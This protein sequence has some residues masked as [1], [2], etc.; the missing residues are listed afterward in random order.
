MPNWNRVQILNIIASSVHNVELI[1]I[2]GR[3]PCENHKGKAIQTVCIV[4]WHD[5][6]NRFH[7]EGVPIRGSLEINKTCKCTAVSPSPLRWN[8]YKVVETPVIG[9]SF[10]TKTACLECLEVTPFPCWCQNRMTVSVPKSDWHIFSW[11]DPAGSFPCL[12]RVITILARPNWWHHTGGWVYPVGL[13]RCV[14]SKANWRLSV[15]QEFC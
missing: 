2:Q 13:Q 8:S 11:H 6:W 4:W 15:K 9:S 14:G 5:L 10:K 3:S 1:L 7:L 12:T